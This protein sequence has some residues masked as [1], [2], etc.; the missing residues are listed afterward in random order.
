MKLI[1]KGILAGGVVLVVA[2]CFSF[3]PYFP[4]KR[5]E[6]ANPHQANEVIQKAQGIQL[7]FIKNEEQMD[8]AVAFFT[9]TFQGGVFVTKRGEIV[10]SLKERRD[11][12]QAENPNTG[13]VR[14]IVLKE[15][16]IDGKVEN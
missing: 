7:P 10:Y 8:E 9:N 3:S 2:A 5:V 12:A 1:N 16:F 14:R 13:R 6:T 15:E 11:E 4:G